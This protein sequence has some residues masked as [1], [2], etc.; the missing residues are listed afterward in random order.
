MILNL[1]Y[2]IKWIYQKIL[3]GMRSFGH[4]NTIAIL[5]N[6][7]MLCRNISSQKCSKFNCLYLLSEFSSLHYYSSLTVC[8]SNCSL[9]WNKIGAE[10]GVALE[11][12]LTVNQTLQTL[13]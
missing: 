2:I 5:L 9:N 11:E 6:F 4:T 8:V 1:K 12:A 3:L 7:V 10:G 13:R